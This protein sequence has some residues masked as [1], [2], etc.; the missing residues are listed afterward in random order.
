[1]SEKTSER[2]DSLF[3]SDKNGYDLIGAEDRALCEKYAIEYKAF[4]NKSKTEREAV[5]FAEKMAKENGFVPY[6]RGMELKA[7]D[8][9]FKNIR[10]KRF[11][12]PL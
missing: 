1:M 11:S 5:C 2:R 7:G 9:V 3:R 8:R 10:K 4:L 12:L 6:E